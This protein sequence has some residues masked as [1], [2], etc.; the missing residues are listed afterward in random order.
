MPAIRAIAT[1]SPPHRIVQD[2]ARDFARRLFADD[3]DFFARM[4]SVYEN[5]GIDTRDLCVP[6]AW[7]EEPHGWTDRNGVFTEQ[8]LTLLE[9]AARD[10]LARAEIAAEAVDVLVTVSSTGIAT[11]SLDARL[12]ERLAFRRDVMRLPVFGLGC[13]GGT[14]GLGRAAALARAEPGSIVLLLVVELCGLAFRR[15]DRR[16]S[17][18]IAT[19]L[20]GDGAAACLIRGAD[21]G[22]A[23]ALADVSGWGEYTWPDSLDV[24]G[25]SIEAD[26]FGV[27]FSRDIP[28]MIRQGLRP[29]ADAFLARHG[30]T[31]EDLRGLVCHP[32]GTKVLA[33]IRDA[34]GCPDAELDCERGVLRRHGNM[35][36]PTVLF[37]LADRLARKPRGLHMM[38][39]LGPGF[40]VGFALLDFGGA[41]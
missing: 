38:L 30:H 17:N 18:V 9:R 12:M 14:I 15:D 26:G 6:P 41:R 36:A 19:A 2:Q 25:W 34:L 7:F 16:K 3:P 23:G 13:A 5:A 28:A 24:M 1:A 4:V 33:A 10:C 31:V 29:A 35:S 40:T 11:P 27:I 22:S 20:F 32:G 21:G 39:A 37:V 8:A